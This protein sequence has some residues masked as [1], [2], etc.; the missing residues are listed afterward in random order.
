MVDT[1]LRNGT[2]VSG[3]GSNSYIADIAIKNE[4][5][6]EIST[7]ISLDCREEIDVTGLVVS[8]GFIDAHGHSEL[9]LL[10]DPD[11][12]SKLSQGVTT[13]IVG[14]CGLTAFPVASEFRR[15]SLGFIDVPGLEWKWN[16]TV[17]YIDFIKSRPSDINTV[18]LVGHGSIRC[19]V[20]GYDSRTANDSEIADMKLMLREILGMGIMGLSTGLGYAPDVYSNE[21]EL[22]SLA[23]VIREKDSIFT[24]HPRGER[25]TYFKAVSE[26]VDVARKSGAF[27]EI[28]HLKCGHPSNRGRMQEILNILENANSEG[29]GIGFDHYPYTAGNSYLGLVFPPWVH[30]KGMDG[31]LKLLSDSMDRDKIKKEIIFGCD[32]WTSF[33]AH[34]MGKSIHISNVPLDMA[35]YCGRNLIEVADMMSVDVPEACC[36]LMEDANGKV[37]ILM[38]QQQDSDLELAMRNKL[39]IFGSDGFAMDTGELIKKGTP[40]PRSFG[41]FPR[42][43]G[44]YVRD[45]GILSLEEAIRKMTS[46]VADR[47]GL[48]DRGRLYPGYKADIV[49]FDSTR[50]KDTS[51]YEHPFSYA[52]GIKYVFVNGEC[53]YRDGAFLSK[54]NGKLILRK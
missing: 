33:I 39:G 19:A 44:H 8:P 45:K 36:R 28:S 6:V 12:K 43:L 15:K 23:E 30:S 54:R 18:P 50:I 1:I 51:T 41:T 13:E 47:F 14:N 26:I 35:E 46:A 48:S 42:I 21:Y 52:Y 34:D 29:V 25:E 5:I 22:I 38:F 53:S 2:I 40:H 17:S 49:V 4:E 27:C 32:N 24:F 31:L 37:E 7:H 3:D 10:V 20:M 11:G 9:T 16:D